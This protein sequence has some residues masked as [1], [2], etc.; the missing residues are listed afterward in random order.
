MSIGQCF[1]TN[2][3]NKLALCGTP[4]FPEGNV[5]HGKFLIQLQTLAFTEAGAAR[6]T[7][8]AS[9]RSLQKLER[10]DTQVMPD[11]EL[12]M[13]DWIVHSVFLKPL[14]NQSQ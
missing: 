13:G 8:D 4:S 10:H 3:K 7:S 1:N 14:T 11:P 9:L 6:Y 5:M 2:K 12:A